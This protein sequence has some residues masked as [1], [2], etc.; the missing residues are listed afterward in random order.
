MVVISEIRRRNASYA[1]QGHRGLVCVFAGATAGIGA[2]TLRE[3]VGLLHSSTFYV[4]GRDP[5]RYQDKL[6]EL[7]KLGPSNNIVFIE[8]QIALISGIDKACREISAAAKKID[9]ICVSPG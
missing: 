6:D 1:S 4:L 8:T 3:M 5:H 7:K 9:V 2:A